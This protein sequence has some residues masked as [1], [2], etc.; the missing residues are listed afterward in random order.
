[1]R[2]SRGRR[3]PATPSVC[4]CRLR[5]HRVIPA[6]GTGHTASAGRIITM[7]RATDRARQHDRPTAAEAT[8]AAAREAAEALQRSLDSRW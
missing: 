2:I 7:D 3:N 6:A 8:A 5:R 1:M 4:R